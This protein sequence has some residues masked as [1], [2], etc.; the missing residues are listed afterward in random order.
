MCSPA[1][2]GI[3]GLIVSAVGTGASIYNS[4]QQAKQAERDQRKSLAR[5]NKIIRE[6]APAE[7]EVITTN[8]DYVRRMAKI[9]RGIAQTIY[10]NRNNNQA[11]GMFGKTAV[12]GA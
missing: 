5:Q 12:L 9:R 11:G 3:A 6:A 10:S 1:A 8:E 7:A 2:V 4:N